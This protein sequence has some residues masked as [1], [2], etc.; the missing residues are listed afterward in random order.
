[1]K[2]QEQNQEPVFDAAM[3]EVV[4]TSFV[5]S[6][7]QFLRLT[8]THE[9]KNRIFEE[10]LNQLMRVSGSFFKIP[11]TIELELSFRGEHIFINKMRLRPRSRQFYV[12]RF[13]LKFM[14]F[15][16]IGVFRL[17]KAPQAE[18]ML[19]V[20][21]QMA[22]TVMDEDKIEPVHK[23]QAALKEKNYDG[24]D[25]R[26][27]PK[28]VV[29]QGEAG[30]GGLDDVEIAAVVI[31][32][33]IRKFADTCLENLE[34]AQKFSPE[35]L[36][37]LTGDLGLLGEEDIVQ[38]LRLISI[39]RYDRPDAYR[40]VNS[41]F[42]VSAWAFSLRLPRGVV[43]EIAGAALAHP[44]SLDGSGRPQSLLTAESRGHLLMK[45]ERLK[46]VWP[47]T[48]LQLLAL[49]EWGTPY[50]EDGV[51]QIGTTKCYTHFFGRMI[52]I[53]SDFEMMTTV[54]PGQRVYLPDEALAAMIQSNG[55]Y[56]P[57][58]LK[59]FVNWMGVYP[60]GSL[61]QLQTGEVAQIFAGA[62]D[63]TKFTRPLVTILK[64]P[65]GQLLE[66]P[67]IFDLSTMNEKLGTYRKSIKK[68]LSIDEAGIPIERFKMT[69]VGL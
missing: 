55:V 67:E 60:V 57:T 20:L 33:R 65:R 25:L 40:A 50:G 2:I 29:G 46:Q 43:S 15:R 45:V 31:Y 24:F 16:R 37:R 27:T 14:R 48:D 26:I 62:A 11:G 63:P 61:V 34:S 36:D 28:L 68:S 8:E 42:L 53:T 58:F 9:A 4:A 17:T 13:L 7:Y 49:M 41:C 39:K 69:P 23:L 30:E 19:F 56:D 32:E 44:L 64:D 59:L 12:Y 21:W 3:L 6:L 10:S 38:M 5:V 52:R 18:A 51:Y 47:L 66:R 35:S 54:I 1:M 22:K